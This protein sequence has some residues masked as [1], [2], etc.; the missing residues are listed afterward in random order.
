MQRSGSGGGGS[1]A[2]D[3]ILLLVRTVQ[4][5]TYLESIFTTTSQAT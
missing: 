2:V 3:I 1:V 5:I 4:S